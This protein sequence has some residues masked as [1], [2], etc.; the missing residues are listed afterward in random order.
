MLDLLFVIAAV[1]R[2]RQYVF[3]NFFVIIVQPVDQ[4]FVPLEIEHSVVVEA[5]DQFHCV[6]LSVNL[7]V[8]RHHLIDRFSRNFQFGFLRLSHK[9]GKR[10]AIFAGIALSPEIIT[11]IAGLYGFGFSSGIH[12]FVV[13]LA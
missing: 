5:F 3:I 9:G 12:F 8:T 7:H 4:F 1:V 6:R 10:H 11:F 13:R 2:A